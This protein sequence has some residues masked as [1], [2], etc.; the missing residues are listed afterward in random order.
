MRIDDSKKI[1]KTL[2]SFANTDGGRLLIGVKDNGSVFGCSVEEE[3]HMIEAASEMYCDP[4]VSFHIQPWKV[5]F[6]NVLEVVVEPSDIRPHFAINENDKRRAYIRQDD[7]NIVANGVQLKVWEHDRDRV[8]GNF[9]YDEEKEKLFERFKTRE[10]LGFRAV[11][12]ITKLNPKQTEELLAQLI[13]WD[14]VEM[15]VDQGRYSF[16]LRSA[17]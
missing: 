17:S 5:D 3:R 12:R 16:K 9:E 4:P 2:V 11:S 7:K 6:M 1:A 14:V 13:K 10:T 15:H 8:Y